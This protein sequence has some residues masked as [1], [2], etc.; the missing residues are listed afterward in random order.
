MNVTSKV[1]SSLANDCHQFLVTS[2]GFAWPRKPQK[3]SWTKNFRV[4][5]HVLLSV[6]STAT[7]LRVVSCIEAGGARS[8]VPEWSRSS[9]FLTHNAKHKHRG[10]HV[11][12]NSVVLVCHVKINGKTNRMLPAETTMATTA[13]PVFSNRRNIMCQSFSVNCCVNCLTRKTASMSQKP[14]QW[15]NH[16]GNQR[17]ICCGSENLKS[18]EFD[19]ID[20]SG[21]CLIT[22]TINGISQTSV[23]LPHCPVSV[24][25]ADCSSNWLAAHQCGSTG[26][27]AF[28]RGVQWND[29]TAS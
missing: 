18:M 3:S 21:S 16:H 29:D 22:G 25:L 17:K 1:Q 11:A 7:A 6:V 27:Q 4:T 28:A 10:V 5:H 20:S 2:M 9:R 8:S 19:S 12:K 24:L 23:V 13:I 15:K 14:L 26:Q